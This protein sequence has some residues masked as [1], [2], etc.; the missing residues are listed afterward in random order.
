MKNRHGTVSASRLIITA[1]TLTTILFVV[2]VTYTFKDKKGVVKNTQS[3]KNLLANTSK[4]RE[5]NITF[6]EEKDSDGDGL[7]DWEEIRW[8]TD[9]HNADTDGNGVG[10]KEQTSSQDRFTVMDASPLS[11]E[12]ST[13]KEPLTM[14][15]VASRELFGSYMYSLKSGKTLSTADQEAIVDDALHAVVPMIQFST[16]TQDDVQKVDSTLENKK[17]YVDDL[18]KTLKDIS[19]IQNEALALYKISQN[20]TRE[21]GIG[22]IKKSVD[23][24]R[25]YVEQLKN[26]TVPIDAVSIHTEFLTSL[27]N[28]IFA[29]ENFI[30]FEKDPIRSAVS[31]NTML[32]LFSQVNNSVADLTGYM[33]SAKKSGQTT[34]SN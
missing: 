25:A 1:I 28:Y 30:Y 12:V 7:A 20:E 3:S 6:N 21:E 27:E 5:E 23:G 19:D 13:R 2:A 11:L 22:E 29:L 31:I 34:T 15:E 9:P 17:R 16:F 33:L 32:P 14:T 26:M 24:Y 10:D 4:N 8:S 18:Q